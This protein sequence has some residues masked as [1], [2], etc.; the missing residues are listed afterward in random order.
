MECTS[1]GNPLPVYCWT[2]SLSDS[3]ANTT[4][5]GAEL[6]VDVCNLTEWSQTSEKRTVSGTTRLMLTCHAE[7]TV[8]GQRRIASVREVYNLALPTNMDK[9]CGGEII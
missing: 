3:T 2:A 4:S 9:V 5:T 8:R 7:N 1:E 6:V